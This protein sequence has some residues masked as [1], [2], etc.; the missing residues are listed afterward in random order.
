MAEI[1]V[2]LII[3]LATGAPLVKVYDKWLKEMKGGERGEQP[4][5]IKK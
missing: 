2:A 4:Q 5:S 1:I 3:T